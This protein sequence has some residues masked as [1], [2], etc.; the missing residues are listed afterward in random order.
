[1]PD[2]QALLTVTSI[3]F[4]HRAASVFRRWLVH[5]ANCEDR[6]VTRVTSRGADFIGSLGAAFLEEV[7]APLIEFRRFAK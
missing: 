4:D 7:G 1:M 2:L 5:S 6:P 3:V